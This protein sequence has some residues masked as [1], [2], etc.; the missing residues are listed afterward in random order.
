M[1]QAHGTAARSGRHGPKLLPVAACL[2]VMTGAAVAQ[3]DP[4]A[5]CAALTGRDVAA[6][7]IGLPTSGATVTSATAVVP[8]PAGRDAASPAQPDHCRVLGTIAPV[9]PQ[10][11]PIRFQLNLPLPSHWNGKALQYGG[12]GFNGVLITGL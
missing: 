6:A 3:P 7:A 1:K 9:D 2:A 10:A 8:S 4:G 12:G 11:P 5:A